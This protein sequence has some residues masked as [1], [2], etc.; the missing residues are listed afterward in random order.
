MIGD[1]LGE[2]RCAITG[3]NTVPTQKPIARGRPYSKSD[4]RIPGVEALSPH[5][6]HDGATTPATASRSSARCKLVS[7]VDVDRSVPESN[8]GGHQ[9]LMSFEKQ[10]RT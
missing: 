3:K 1:P 7:M 9:I 6:A 2:H 4:R 10:C 8:E 5:G